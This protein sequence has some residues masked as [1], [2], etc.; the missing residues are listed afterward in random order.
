MA[1]AGDIIVA[2]DNTRFCQMEAKRGIAPLGGAH[3]RYRTCGWGNGMY[4]LLLCD[5]FDAAQAY[6]VGLVQEVVPAGTQ[7]DRAMELANIIKR[8][9]PLGIQATKLAGR[10]YIEAGEALP[11]PPLLA[12]ASR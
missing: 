3:F 1:L 9:A 8:N 7:I 5:E 11:L 6:R 2:A 4:H 12:F 10:K